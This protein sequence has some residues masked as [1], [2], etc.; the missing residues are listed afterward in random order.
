VLL[1]QL[2]WVEVDDE[3]VD[4]SALL[5]EQHALRAYGAVHLAAARRLSDDELVVVA[6]DGALLTAAGQLGLTTAA[7]G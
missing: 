5:A 2:D 3:R 7:I 6:G 1:A 4:G